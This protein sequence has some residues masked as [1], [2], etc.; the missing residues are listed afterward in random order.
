MIDVDLHIKS[1]TQ[2]TYNT[3]YV[4]KL[5]LTKNKV[6]EITIINKTYTWFKLAFSISES[7]F[8]IL[9]LFKFVICFKII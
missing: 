2:K 9:G 4:K 8:L 3:A 1:P 6:L 5:T 7:P